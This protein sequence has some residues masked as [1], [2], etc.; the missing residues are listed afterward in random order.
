MDE[1]KKKKQKTILV[2]AVLVFGVVAAIGSGVKFLSPE[3]EQVV[4]SLDA[5]GGGGGMRDAEAGV[6]A[7]APRAEGTP[8]PPGVEGGRGQ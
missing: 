4:G 6:D 1:E 5:P 3:K 2:V 8:P 7:S